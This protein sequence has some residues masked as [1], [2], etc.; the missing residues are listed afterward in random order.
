M[1]C[2]GRVAR[3]THPWLADHAVRDT[4][5]LPATAVLELLFQAGDPAGC[6]RVDELVISAPLTLPDRGGVQ[7]QVSVGAADAAGRRAATVWARPEDGDE[8]WTTHATGV[9]APGAPA[10]RPPTS[11]SGHPPVPSRSTWTCCA[12]GSARPDS[13]TARRSRPAGAL[14]GGHRPVRRR[15]A[16]AGPRDRER[17]LRLHPAL[18]DAALQAMAAGVADD[19]PGRLPFSFTGVSCTPRVRQRCGSASVQ[20]ATARWRWP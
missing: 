9:L 16:A 6:R 19:E 4:V 1:V 14:A 18:F 8:P 13:A 3:L 20:P 10:R 2:T 5:L 17:A 12:T 7:L 11:A 15:R